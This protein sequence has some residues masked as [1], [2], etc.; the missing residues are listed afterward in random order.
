[1]NGKS[2]CKILKNIRRKIAEDHQIQ[3]VITECKYQGNCSGTCPKCEAE[4]RYLEKELSKRKSL[5]KS[6]AVAGI[7]AA[8]VVSSA[9]CDV[10]IPD[11]TQTSQTEATTTQPATEVPGKIPVDTTSVD[12]YVEWAGAPLPPVETTPEDE[13]VEWDGEPV[14]MGD[15][16]MPEES[17]WWD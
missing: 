6:V 12:E 11:Q 15:V 9:G 17:T 1:M 14:L 13:Y 8:L 5:G 16:P 7:A 3:F 2:K 10:K 4:L